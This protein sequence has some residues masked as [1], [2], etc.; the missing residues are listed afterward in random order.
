MD[1]GRGAVLGG[2]SLALAPGPMVG[3]IGPN[4]A[5]KS[6]LLKLLMGLMRPTTGT[7]MLD[8]RPLHGYR[9]RAL[10]R[11]MTL[12]PQD[13]QVDFGFSVEEVVAM[14][15]NPYLGHFEVPGE[16]DLTLI[17][18]AMDRTGV[19]ELADRSITTLSSGERQRAMI[20]RAI[21]QETPIVLL[22]EVTANLDLCHQLAVLE[23]VQGL[24]QSGRLVVAAIHDLTLA[25]RFCGRLV[26]LADGRIQA[27]GPPRAVLTRAN[28]RRWFAVEAQ[29]DEGVDGGELRIRALR[30]A[31]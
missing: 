11:R 30:P 28:L 7:I 1:Y 22:D 26:L 16:A 15:R 4:G 24:A 31:A 3:L 29:V 12:V 6:T 23:L 9:R 21:A 19:T 2:L 13:T 8:G 27:D 17:R 20:A 14:G 10:A 25:A 5:G 18:Q